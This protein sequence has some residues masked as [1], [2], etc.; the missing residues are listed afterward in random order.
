MDDEGD[1]AAAD[2]AEIVV[3]LGLRESDWSKL[4]PEDVVPLEPF[5][6]AVILERSDRGETAKTGTQ[7]TVR[8]D[9]VGNAA[10]LLR[11]G[12]DALKRGRKLNLLS[13]LEFRVPET[14][15]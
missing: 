8:V 4:R 13:G 14:S 6:V 1:K 10:K 9:H 5:G 3:D 11:W 12:Q 15:S 2:V 7:Q